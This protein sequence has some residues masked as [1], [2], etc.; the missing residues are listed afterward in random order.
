MKIS[1]RIC[2]VALGILLAAA[3][4]TCGGGTSDTTPISLITPYKN[5]T[6]MAEIR[7]AFSSSASAPW[8]F[9]H[10]GIDCMPNGNLK[11]F[12]AVCSGVVDRL[13]LY[14]AE[15]I[16]E[17]HV[18]V[19][20]KYNDTYTVLYLFEPGPLSTRSDAETQLANILVSL[21]QHVSQGD[22]IGNLYYTG[23]DWAFVDFGLLE[24]GVR[25]CPE[26]YFAP[27]ARDSILT[28]LHVRH[29]GANMCYSITLDTTAPSNVSV[30]IDNGAASTSS[31][32]VMLS[33]AARDNIGV[34]GYYISETS[35][36]PSAMAPGWTLVESRIPYSA[37]VPFILSSGDGTKTIYVWF[38]DGAGNVSA[39]ATASITLT[40]S[41]I[42]MI[43]PYKNS[44]DMVAMMHAF[45]SSA[46]APW[47][48]EHNGIDCWPN[49]NL[50]P[51]QAV[52][53]GVV[54]RLE[55][56]GNATSDQHVE[57]EIKY[58]DTYTVMYLFEPAPP[59]ATRSDAE[60]Q[61]ANIQVSLGQYV[62]QGD[63]IGN[64]YAASDM[65]IVHFGLLEDGVWIC[66]E[67]YFT[68]EAR[69]S[70]LAL[71]H[72]RYPGANMCY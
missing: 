36:T 1:L 40:T 9:E 50:K 64:L 44:T 41:A 59:R 29:P 20:I 54:S 17:W 13:E 63:I 24:D 8:G 23:G 53:S 42:S 62:S 14:Y 66:P 26:P 55:L 30:M 67:P 39:P 60:I 21:G 69:D 45:S 22:I 25:I 11:P 32:T 33:I 4:T 38:K 27:E 5:S 19:G 49:G 18:N 15:A 48:F 61:L 28:L 16:S 58:N 6:D 2:G 52:C 57:V 71:L 12:Q 35:T 43:T 34:T 47:S 3:L 37:D 72:V 70:I 65:P 46:S 51:F 10:L 56:W 68:S 31:T 7:N